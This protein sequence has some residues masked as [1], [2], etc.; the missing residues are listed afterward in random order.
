MSKHQIHAVWQAELVATPK[1]EF[2]T[3]IVLRQ[4]TLTTSF[5]LPNNWATYAGRKNKEGNRICT[6]DGAAKQHQP[7]AAHHQHI[8]DKVMP[9]T[10]GHP[11][12]TGH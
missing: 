11:T 1:G 10:V 8:M 4:R 5:L 12:G 3:Y 6:T 9:G 7:G 2:I